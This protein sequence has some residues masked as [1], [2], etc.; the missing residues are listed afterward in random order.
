MKIVGIIQARTGSKRLPNKVLQELVPGV[1]VLEMLVMR[2][3]RSTLLTHIY[4]ATTILSEDT[5]IVELA[6]RMNIHLYRGD[7]LDVQSRYL[8]VASISKADIIVRITSDCPFLDP[9]I[10]DFAIMTYIDSPAN[11]YVSTALNPYYSAG[12]H[13]EVMSKE[14]SYDAS[15][16]SR[17]P[18]CIEHV[19]PYIYNNP[20]K[21]NCIPL[22]SSV[23]GSWARLTIDFEDDLNFARNLSSCIP[24]K[25]ASLGYILDYLKVNQHLLSINSHHILDQKLVRVYVE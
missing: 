18:D 23:D 25:S 2:L 5:P 4:I 15:Y 24:W 13:V 11:S 9:S 10:V 12:Q 22:P 19:T 17:H 1:S 20:D 14:I 21:Y 16:R 6:K 8:N 3:R 7:P